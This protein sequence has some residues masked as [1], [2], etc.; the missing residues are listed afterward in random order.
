[1]AA[2]DGNGHLVLYQGMGANPSINKGF[3]YQFSPDPSYNWNI[4]YHAPIRVTNFNGDGGAGLLAVDRSGNL[5]Y[6]PMD[7]S[8]TGDLQ[9]D[10]ARVQH[11]GSGWNQFGNIIAINNFTGDGKLAL[12]AVGGSGAGQG[13]VRLYEHGA[14][15]WGASGGGTQIG[16]GFDQFAHLMAFQW[17]ND[18]HVGLLGVTT[19]GDLRYY[20]VDG[21][22]NWTNGGG[23]LIGGGFGGLSAVFSVGSFGGSDTGSIMT[24]NNSGILKVYEASGIGSWLSGNGVLI[25]SGFTPGNITALF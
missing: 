25:G 4:S 14:N 19:T 23:Q 9:V 20:G 3:S 24:V 12:L 18:G 16:A 2:L 17:T 8:A 13:T 1:V 22:G 6:F 7:Q 5:D 11:V 10:H 15:G 21:R